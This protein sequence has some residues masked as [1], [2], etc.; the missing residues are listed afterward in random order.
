MTST[1]RI[2]RVLVNVDRATATGESGDL[3]GSIAFV[4]RA[5][6]ADDAT[7][8]ISRPD[9]HGLDDGR[10]IGLHE[11]KVVDVRVTRARRWASVGRTPLMVDVAL[12]PV[13]AG[14]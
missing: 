13:V 6:S 5:E 2:Y 9:G 11:W 8:Y 10:R 3:A 14:R 4:V 7:R 12:S 1:P